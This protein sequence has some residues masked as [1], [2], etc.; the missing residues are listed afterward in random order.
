MR[1]GS[2]VHWADRLA[3]ELAEKLRARGKEE[4]VFN[5][6]LSVSGLQHIGRLRGEVILGEVLRRILEVRGFKIR[7]LLTLYTQDAWKGKEAQL[8]RFRD[9]GEAE[10]YR[11]WPLI[12]VPDPEGCHSN[13]VEHFWEDF[14]KYLGEFTDGRIE[15][16]TTTELY[17][18]ALRS[19]VEE[20]LG[21]REEARRIINKYRGRR[22][23]PEGWIPFEPICGG[24]GR[25]DSTEAVGVEDG[26]V[27][28]V[29][30]SCGYRGEAELSEGK[31]NWRLEWAGI[32]KALEVDFEPFGKDHATPGGSRDSCVELSR[33]LLG[34]EPPEGIPYEWVA[35]R[36]PDGRVSDM[37]SSDFVGVTPRQWLEVAHAE[38]L[39][40]L[41]LSVP[42]MRKIIVGMAEIPSYYSKYYRAERLFYGVEEASSEEDRDTA[43]SYELAQ[44]SNP[45][46]RMPIQIPY[47]HMALMVQTLPEENR[48]E[49]ALRRLRMSK[50]ITGDLSREDEERIRSLLEKAARWVEKYAPGRYRIRILE[51]LSPEIKGKLEMK[52]KLVELG[53]KLE[54]LEDWS[55]DSV[56]EAMIRVTEGMSSGERRRF[57][58]EF[59][60][61]FLG[62]ESG[63]RAAPMVASMDKEFVAR[64]LTR[65][66]LD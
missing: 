28:Y 47:T 8:A 65:D 44:L 4:Y 50:M 36:M 60:L 49:E 15:I 55:V 32:W 18:G 56:K 6:G 1:R 52:D 17:R 31:L 30:R 7:Q 29:C 54:G 20:V 61:V 11:G 59:Y 5:G 23:Y 21:K 66:L 24:C 53:R 35:I 9:P 42:P 58:R 26:R 10:K 63:P 13:W 37:S 14:G 2:M 16:V 3:E 25:I 57:Y 38:V 22:P 43:R 39:R 12:R 34:Y 64:R 46:S 40:F 27:Q 51:T 48:V 19:I 41:Y 33:S 45:P 62:S